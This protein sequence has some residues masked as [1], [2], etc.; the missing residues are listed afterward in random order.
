[1]ISKCIHSMH[2]KIT[3][4]LNSYICYR[5][6]H[7]LLLLLLL[8]DRLLSWFLNKLL[9]IIETLLLNCFRW[10]HMQILISLSVWSHKVRRLLN[11]LYCLIFWLWLILD[12]I[13]EKFISLFRR[14]LI[15]VLYCICSLSQIIYQCLIVI[16][17]SIS[18][19]LI[20]W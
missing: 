6:S 16:S 9:I 20:L 5:R 3:L 15:Q 17:H 4:S 13:Y 11:L 7:L 10:I 14:K 19:H 18:L 8:F 1:M 12:F 2:F